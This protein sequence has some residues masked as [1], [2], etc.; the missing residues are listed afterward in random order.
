[1][2]TCCACLLL[3][4]A[5]LEW[6]GEED[7]GGYIAYASFS[8]ESW[9][10]S[11]MSVECAVPAG[12]SHLEGSVAQVDYRE[13][14][15]KVCVLYGHGAFTIE[16]VCCLDSTLLFVACILLLPLVKWC[17]GSCCGPVHTAEAS[18]CGVALCAF[19]SGY[20]SERRV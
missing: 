1:M 17:P 4:H 11:G 20:D 14:E 9:L 6:P 8:M 3:L 18:S 15:G 2:W 10:V 19:I 7:F 5:R 16:N 13:A 12:P